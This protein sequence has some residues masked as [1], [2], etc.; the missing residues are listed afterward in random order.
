MFR[1]GRKKE[2]IIFFTPYLNGE[3]EAFVEE[4]EKASEDKQNVRFI[5]SQ[6]ERLITLGEK[7][8][9]VEK[10]DP[11]RLLF[12][13]VCAEAVAKL[14]HKFN[15]EAKSKEYTKIFF[16][17]LCC[18][19]DFKKLDNSLSIAK[20]GGINK[21]SLSASKVIDFLYKVRC[22]VVHEGVYWEFSFFKRNED[23]YATPIEKTGEQVYSKLKYEELKKIVVNGVISSVKNLLK[24]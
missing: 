1:Q 13:F 14:Y 4:C 2:L 23:F 7:I 15:G 21:R 18:F 19:H 12:L 24:R 5:I 9:K 10:N 3:T 11:L 16:E 8:Y 22:S 17:K 20:L 6:T